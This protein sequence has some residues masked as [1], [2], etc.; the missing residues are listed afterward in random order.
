MYL[1]SLSL[2]LAAG[3]AQLPEGLRRRHAEYLR[4][5]QRDDGGFAG[6]QG[7]SD[8]YYTGFGLRGLALTGALD[9]PAAARAASFLAA[10]LGRPLPVI[11]LLS[12]HYGAALLEVVAGVDVFA[13]AGRNRVPTLLA[14]AAPLRRPDGGYAKTPKGAH[15]S[16][17]LTFL[18]ALAKD[19][20]GLEHEDPRRS[21]EMVLSCQRDDGG[22]VELAPLRQS[23][24]NPT[25]AAVGLL[26]M[27]DALE[28][29]A[30]GRAVRF[31][32][33]MQTPEGGLRANTQIP[34]A[35]LLSTFTGLAALTDLDALDAVDLK[36]ARAYAHSLELSQGGFRGAA[37]DTGTD[38]E[39]TFYG[40]GTLALLP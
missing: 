22:F 20:L 5:A 24:T 6:R 18:V 3:A 33:A 40:L 31:L 9:E 27:L 12:L 29:P 35:D 28:D 14:A 30:Q 37:W 1:R 11:D 26:K 8:P 21:V 39:Y 36:A 4:A 23:G 15:S 2:R 13:E 16:T 17:Y 32:A 7:P 34:V 10:A 38:V 25:S 19:L